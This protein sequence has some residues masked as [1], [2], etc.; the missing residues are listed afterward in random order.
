M[1][2]TIWEQHIDY[3]TSTVLRYCSVKCQTWERLSSRRNWNPVVVRLG[4]FPG[5]ALQ[6]MCEEEGAGGSGKGRKGEEREK[7]RGGEKEGEGRRGRRGGE[8]REKGGGGV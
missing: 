4:C 5:W 2:K 3:L 1:N 7:G 6:I 8:E